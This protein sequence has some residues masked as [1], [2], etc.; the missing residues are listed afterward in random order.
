MFG[1]G[2]PR[3][4]GLPRLTGLETQGA[5]MLPPS[6][7]IGFYYSILAHPLQDSARFPAW[8]FL[9]PRRNLGKFQLLSKE[10]ILSMGHLCDILLSIV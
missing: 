6:P 3:Y 1:Q 2:R 4:T 10:E 5:R 9:P 8:P 7:F